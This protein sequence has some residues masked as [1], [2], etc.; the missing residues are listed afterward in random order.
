MT[1]FLSTRAA[2][3]SLLV[4]CAV[5]SFIFAFGIFYIY[6]LLRTG[7][8]GRLILPPVFAIPNRPLSVVDETLNA[9]A[10]HLSIGE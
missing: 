6:R 9:D 2:A 10:T 8:A 4:F 1:P 5:Y 3:I 7:P